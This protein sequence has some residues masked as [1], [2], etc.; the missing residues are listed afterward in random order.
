MRSL[1]SIRSIRI[2]VGILSPINWMFRFGDGSAKEDKLSG[3]DDRGRVEQEDLLH[4]LQL[5]AGVE[6]GCSAWISF[7]KNSALFEESWGIDLER[8]G[9]LFGMCQKN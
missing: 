4:Q 2:E 9:D 1:K 6:L 3:L 5:K 8:N 7:G